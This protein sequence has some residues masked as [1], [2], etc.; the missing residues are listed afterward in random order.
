MPVHTFLEEAVVILAASV[1]VVLL[2]HRLRV[3]SVVGLL[4][5]GLLIGPSGLGLIG[6][7]E[8]VELFAEVGVIFL[9]F[10][11][12]LEFSLDRLKQIRRAFFA[13]GS[14]Q[15][16]LTTAAVALLAAAWGEEPPRAIFLG[17]VVTLSSTAIVLKLY[18]ER[19]QLDAPQGKLVLGI[20]LFQEFLIVPMI[21]LVPVLSGTA[22]ASAGAVALRFVLALGFIGLVFLVA[23]YLM[24]RLLYAL[25]RTRIREVF[26]LGALA[27]CLGM[28]LLT[29][30]LEF[31]LALGAFLAGIVI[32]E[33]EYSPQVVAE[34]APFRDVFTSVFFISIGMLLDL[35]FAAAHLPAIL[36][37]AAAVVLL[38]AA[39]A[40]GAVTLLG[41]ASRI[42]VL[43]GAALAQ[44]GEFSFV[45]LEVG[46][47]QGLLDGATYQTFLAAAILTMLA[48]PLLV[49]LE[50]RLPGWAAARA[51]DEAAAHAGLSGH[52][53]V[54]GFGVA[55]QNLARVLRAAGVPYTVVELNGKLVRT[56]RAAGEPVLFG[57]ATRR[58]ILEHAG[59]ERAR[60]VVFVISDLVAVRHGV[61]LARQMNPGVHIIVRTRMVAEIEDLGRQGADEVI[62][63]EFE[64]SIEIFTRVL[65]HYHVPGNVVRAETRA[66][67]GAH[68]R[69]LRT[70]A[71]A[72]PSELLDLLAAGTTDVFR[73][74]A[75]SPAAGKTLRR[76]ELRK[77]S[78]ST[79]IAVVRGERSFTNPPPDLV[80]QAG[81]SLVLVGS[82]L[83]IDRAFDVLEKGETAAEAEPVEAP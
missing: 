51:A 9:L 44:V 68:Y 19:R 38:K 33:S 81:D 57:D 36:G 52:V 43:V 29:A 61:R 12:G 37:L 31:S 4:L 70:P 10:A 5:T 67:R 83:E 62:A 60:I 49:G 17:F 74:D 59:V 25:V 72:P 18:G 39:L 15:A 20:L 40:G 22:A 53:V 55:G 30:A 69:M 71:A 66:L 42:A 34:V 77:R 26:V 2:S 3:P 75:A 7:V 79:V 58:E 1:A 56:A 16:V 41:F 50:A 82:H 73:L 13:G 47:A 65:N 24:P 46:R 21:V 8:R 48:T 78:G 54:V 23:R 76:L 11:I 63:E 28:A 32:A 27:V 64:T 35:G 45:L 14:L 6:E 80:L